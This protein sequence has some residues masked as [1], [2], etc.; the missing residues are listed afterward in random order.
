MV[1]FV[2]LGA[3]G[4][5]SQLANKICYNY[6]LN[7][8]VTIGGNLTQEQNSEATEILAFISYF[9]YVPNWCSLALTLDKTS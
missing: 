5:C 4:Y 9:Y 8:K 3:R 1:L 6:V 7:L 2:I